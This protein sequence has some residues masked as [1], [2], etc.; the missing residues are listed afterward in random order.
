[1]TLQYR[2]SD[3]SLIHHTAATNASAV[4]LLMSE[5]CCADDTYIEFM[6][7][8]THIAPTFSF[9]SEADRAYHSS[10]CKDADSFGDDCC[11][12]GIGQCA[13]FTGNDKQTPAEAYEDN[14]ST[15]GEQQI[16]GTHTVNGVVKTEKRHCAAVYM[17]LEDFKQMPIGSG[18]PTMAQLGWLPP[19]AGGTT[20][21]IS[22][23]IGGH[24]FVGSSDLRSGNQIAQTTDDNGTNIPECKKIN[25]GSFNTDCAGDIMAYTGSG[26]A[27]APGQLDFSTDETDHIRNL[28]GNCCQAVWT[29]TVDCD[30]CPGFSSDG[31]SPEGGCIE[32]VDDTAQFISFE[33]AKGFALCDCPNLGTDPTT[34]DI[35]NKV[36]GFNFGSNTQNCKFTQCQTILSGE[37]ISDPANARIGGCLDM[38]TYSGSAVCELPPFPGV[39][40]YAFFLG[41]DFMGNTFNC[42]GPS[43]NGNPNPGPYET[44]EE[45]LCR[46][47]QC[48]CSCIQCGQADCDFATCSTSYTVNT[49]SLSVT[50]DFGD[51]PRTLTIA[52]TGISVKAV[53]VNS[54]PTCKANLFSP[55]LDGSTSF[56]ACSV[57]TNR[58]CGDIR[59][60]DG[61]IVKVL[62]DPNPDNEVYAKLY[63]NAVSLVCSLADDP[64]DDCADLVGNAW[65]VVVGFNIGFCNG[66]GCEIP[67]TSTN[68]SSDYTGSYVNEGADDDC[69]PGTYKY[70]NRPTGDP[71]GASGVTFGSTLSV[72]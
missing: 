1:M 47:P 39:F 67:N 13:S 36:H 32:P 50:V 14:C 5:C 38:N 23:K 26:L 33:R 48:S 59:L 10:L 52:G 22:F 34:Q 2:P 58:S 56:E 37:T 30:S 43:C 35:T 42:T 15:S 18:G 25:A 68:G 46:A 54:D 72:S 19:L 21:P 44:C 8:G 12:V 69:P 3:K 61:G 65:G 40:G 29:N 9:C 6:S 71:Y 53:R 57:S 27:I 7:C 63:V 41:G 17:R 11:Q 28:C 62:S 64:S 55:C 45:C 66:A 60:H 70:C 49:P 20:W 24:C 31:T 16:G 51:G 4:N